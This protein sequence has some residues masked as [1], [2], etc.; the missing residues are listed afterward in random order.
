MKDTSELISKRKKRLYYI[1]KKR[2]EYY[3]QRNKEHEG[4]LRNLIEEVP[5]VAQWT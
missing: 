2:P 4:S 5:V 1:H 3:M